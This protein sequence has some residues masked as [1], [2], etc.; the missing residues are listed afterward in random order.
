M[1]VRSR[2]HRG[3]LLHGRHPRRK[4]RAVAA[5]GRHGQRAA[6]RRRHPRLLRTGRRPGLRRP[7]LRLRRPH[8][9]RSGAGAARRRHGPGRVSWFALLLVPLALYAAYKLVGVALKLV[10]A[11]VVVVAVYWW[12]AP[13]MGRSEERCAG[14]ESVRK[15]RCWWWAYN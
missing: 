12:A 2:R 5:R 4:G 1:L 7:L 6:A 13:Q 3:E 14:K 10:L 8:R 11:V 15:C 9:P